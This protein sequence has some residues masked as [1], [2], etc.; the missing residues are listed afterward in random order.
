ME[1][2]KMVKEAL[3]INKEKEEEFNIP[4]EKWKCNDVTTCGPYTMYRFMTWLSK[5]RVKGKGKKEK[6]GDQ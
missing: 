1:R 4:P 2:E 3:K 6:F 5:D